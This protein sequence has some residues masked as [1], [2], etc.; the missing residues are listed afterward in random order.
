MKMDE[1][2]DQEGQKRVGML[3]PAEGKGDEKNSTSVTAANV[4]GRVCEDRRTR[5]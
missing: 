1:E 4:H 2:V 5:T 3:G